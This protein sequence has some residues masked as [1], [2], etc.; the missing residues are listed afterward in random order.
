MLRVAGSRQVL[1]AS[2]CALAL[3]ACGS[4]GG[5]G[6][7]GGTTPPPIGGN[8]PPSGGTV[9]TTPP[10]VPGNLA[11]VALTPSQV[12]VSWDASSD[13]G[14]GVAGYRVYRDGNATPIANV[15]V[16]HY[17]DTGLESN[18]A[19]VYTVRAFDAASPPN[20][21]ALT[22]SVSVTTPPT[23]PT[24][25]STPPTVP[26]NVTAI[27]TSTTSIQISWSPSTDASGIS[28]YR[29]FREGA[30]VA[31]AVTQNTTFTDTQL[32]P[33]TTYKYFVTAVDGAQPS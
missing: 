19:F 15:T 13:T 24:G 31:I 10:T 33:N 4:G 21:S 7:D 3:A 30:S 25:D 8:P 27:A 26:Q 22:T 9:D 6:N 16:T 29:V 18:T 11:A 23:P 28:E 14:A 17:T 1:I 32:T 2:L 5:D 12:E 20:E